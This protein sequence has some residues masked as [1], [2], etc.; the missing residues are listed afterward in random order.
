MRPSYNKDYFLKNDK[1]GKLIVM[2]LE[3]KTYDT[4]N[5]QRQYCI[6][7]CECGNIVRVEK[8]NLIRN[9]TKSC[10]CN[11]YPQKWNS[12]SWKGV[13]EIHKSYYNRLKF[14]AKNRGYEFNLSID[15]LWKLY[16][17]QN[18]C[19]ALSGTPILFDSK[20][21]LHDRTASL[22]RIDN[23]KGYINGNVQWVHKDI[24]MMKHAF[25]ETYFK[26]VCERVTFFKKDVDFSI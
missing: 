19:C 14:E 20:T 5:R 6:C 15:Y 12:K 2:S 17:I 21:R 22:D 9:L 4:K 16:L 1:Y 11:R 25:N 8:G 24:N 7:K 10:G 3:D 26:D 23:S 18:K 13:G